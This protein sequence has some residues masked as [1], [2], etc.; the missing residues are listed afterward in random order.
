MKCTC[1]KRSC[2]D[3][4]FCLH[5]GCTCCTYEEDGVIYHEEECKEEDC[6]TCTMEDLLRKQCF[7]EE[8]KSND[9]LGKSACIS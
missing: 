2:G 1:K 8:V 5:T 4:S 3:T 9:K 6:M 7:E